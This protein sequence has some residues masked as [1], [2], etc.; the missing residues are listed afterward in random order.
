[1]PSSS[2]GLGSP[3]RPPSSF[4]CLLLLLLPPAALALLLFFLDFF[5]PREA[6]SPFLPDHCSARQPRV[7]RRETLNRSA[8]GLGCWVEQ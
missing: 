1:M 3:S 2:S 8:S 7:W 6:V 5:P 4:L